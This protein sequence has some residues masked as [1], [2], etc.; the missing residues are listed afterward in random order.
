MNFFREIDLE[1]WL[2]EQLIHIENPEERKFF[3]KWMEQTM[4]PMRKEYLEHLK[5]MERE[6]LQ[7]NAGNIGNPIVTAIEERRK[8]DVTDTFLFPMDSRDMEETM[9]DTK[10]MLRCLNDGQGY[11]LYSVYFDGGYR[12]LCQMMERNPYFSARAYTAYGQYKGKV[13]LKRSTRYDGILQRL[14]QD[15]VQ[16]CKEW[17]PINTCYL[18]RMLEVELMQLDPPMEGE[19][20]ER[21]EVDFGEYV[22]QIK[23]HMVPLWNITSSK[24]TTTVYPVRTPEGDFYEHKILGDKLSVNSQYLVSGDCNIWSIQRLNEKEQDIIIRCDARRPIQW[25]LRE[26]VGMRQDRMPVLEYRFNA[27]NPLKK[28]IRTRAEAIHYANSLQIKELN[29]VDVY[30][31]EPK[32][33]REEQTYDMDA[34]LVDRIGLSP[35]SPVLYLKWKAADIM[36][37]WN[38]DMLSYAQTC[39]QGAY[40]QYRIKS[41]IV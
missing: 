19:I 33:F 3:R 41:E 17:I 23:Y 14:Y 7:R 38:L 11:Q 2:S 36:N 37:P 20:V 16:N 22:G 39:F 1:Q 12:E 35:T 18:Q 21:I 27:G 25:T 13:R 34:F 6:L 30:M 4:V 28:A 29:L 40:P 5:N 8:L 32:G 15:F 24:I 31:E 26:I 9:V 10:A